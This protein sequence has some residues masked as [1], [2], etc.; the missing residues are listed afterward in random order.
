ML[1]QHPGLGRVFVNG[2]TALD[3]F[4]RNVETDLPTVRLPSSSGALPMS[5]ADKLTR[6]REV[7]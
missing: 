5:F 1:T 6:W 4:E 7:V 3:L 2:L